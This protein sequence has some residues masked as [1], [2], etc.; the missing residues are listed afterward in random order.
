MVHFGKRHYIGM[1]AL[2]SEGTESLLPL[3]YT[4]FYLYKT[5]G[6]KN[7]AHLMK[8]HSFYLKMSSV[9]WIFQQNSFDSLRYD[10]FVNTGSATDLNLQSIIRLKSF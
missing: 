10:S 6:P 2:Q 3:N 8:T 1:F 5:Y 9:K 4:I 7:M